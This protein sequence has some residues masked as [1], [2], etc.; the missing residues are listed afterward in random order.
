MP[1][2]SVLFSIEQAAA[3]VPVATAA[4]D[5]PPPNPVPVGSVLA[6]R[7][8]NARVAQGAAQALAAAGHDVAL[9]GAWDSVPTEQLLGSDAVLNLCEGLAGNSAREAEAAQQLE[10]AGIPFSGN[11]SEVLRLC[12]RKELCRQRLIQ[13]GVPVPPGVVLHQVPT[14]WPEELPSPCI[15]KPAWEDASEG[16]DHKAVAHDLAGLQ[17]AVARVVEQM[18]EPAVCEAFIDGREITAS[19]LGTPPT[20]LPLGEIDFSSMR[21]GKPRIVCYVA[22]WCPES[23]E[24]NTTP[25]VACKLDAAT[26]ARVR[27]IARQT[28]M[29]LGLTDIARLDFRMDQ[30]RRLYVIDVNPNCD[31]GDDAGFAKAG[32]RAGLS[33][34]Q[35]LERVMQRALSTPRVV[36][37]YATG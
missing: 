19:L 5:G 22:K 28:A 34:V 14:C 8:D 6:S 7:A 29:A 23:E 10:E 16:I 36:R 2:I 11:G 31:L 12:Q 4:D 37:R 3:S 15:V 33:Y 25:S 20:V 27:R 32:R 1:Q 30:Q 21:A 9:V 13:A 17:A 18:G 26:T 35:L 24:Y